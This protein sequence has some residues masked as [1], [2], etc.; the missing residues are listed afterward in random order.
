MK[1]EFRKYIFIEK[2]KRRKINTSKMYYHFQKGR[3]L[4][5]MTLFSINQL[6]SVKQIPKRMKNIFKKIIFSKPN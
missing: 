2:G 4:K 3:H 6:F 5:K 1:N